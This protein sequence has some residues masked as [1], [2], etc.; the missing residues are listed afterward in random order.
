MGQALE[1]NSLGSDY[2]RSLALE[3]QFHRDTKYSHWYQG[4]NLPETSS[5]SDPIKVLRPKKFGLS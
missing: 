3:R 4:I 2:I 1:Q 5:I